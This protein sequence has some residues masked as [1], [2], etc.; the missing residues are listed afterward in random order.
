MG[1]SSTMQTEGPGDNLG[2]VLCIAGAPV[3]HRLTEGT[4]KLPSTLNLGEGQDWDRHLGGEV[5]FQ[6]RAGG[7]RGHVFSNQPLLSQELFL[8]LSSNLFCKPPRK[9]RVIAVT[10]A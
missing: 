5:M 2:P 9:A 6:M 4:N 8:Q 10:D 1:L 3:S 7:R